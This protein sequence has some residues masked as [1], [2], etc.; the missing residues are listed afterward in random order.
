MNDNCSPMF[1]LAGG[2]TGGHIIPAIAIAEEIAKR[3]GRVCFV[4]TRGRLE[5]KLVPKAGFAINYINVRPLVGNSRSAKIVSALSLP[6]SII[7]SAILL[8][9]LKPNAVMGVGGYVAGPVVFAA[10]LLGIPTALLE[11]NATVGFTNRILA[12]TVTKAFVAYEKTMSAFPSSVSYW[13]GNPIK[14]SIIEAA[15]KKIHKRKDTV[16]ILVMGGSQGS[17]AVDR[18]VPTAIVKIK[19]ETKISVIHQCGK[20]NKESVEA[21]YKAAGIHAEVLPFIDNTAEAY[22]QADLVVARSGATTVSELTVMGLPA[23]FL[24]YPHHKDRQQEKNA[25]LMKSLGAAVVLDEKTASVDDIAEAIGKF[26]NDAKYRTNASV[27]SSTLGKK[28]AA[29]H[30]VNELYKM[31]EG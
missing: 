26:V 13:T 10:K 28:D 6:L 8:K 31:I 1:L 9:K 7:R 30:I 21:I 17:S 20:Q 19:F 2:G 18:L 16:C 14:S 15:E 4:G 5:E 29:I 22:A 11:Q 24:P 3:D 25:H 23:V 12:R 27:S